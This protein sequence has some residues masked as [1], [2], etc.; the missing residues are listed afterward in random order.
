MKFSPGRSVL[1]WASAILISFGSLAAAT[2]QLV[3][4]TENY[5][6]FNMQDGET[7]RVIGISTDIVREI[8]KRTKVPYSIKFLPWQRAF[9][10]ALKNEGT[11]VFST[12]ET[13]GRKPNFKWVGPLVENNWT[14][15]GRAD[16]TIHIRSIDDARRFVIGGYKGDA[17]AVFLENEGFSLDLASHDLVNA[18]KLSAGRFDVWATGQY[19]G[20]YL[21][22]QAGVAI[23]PL[24]T[25]RKTVMSLAC[26]KNVDDTLIQRMN[27]TLEELR[28]EG[29]ID[30]IAAKY[31]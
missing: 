10:M 29:F 9:G 6:P 17:V 4:T 2:P 8:M 21:A 23:K 24:F 26:N 19:L 16:S 15:F 5:P 20:P 27:Q 25:F 7:K 1:V 31:A 30:K 28:R 18:R 22:Q 3:L 13:A 11:C 14:F 12:T